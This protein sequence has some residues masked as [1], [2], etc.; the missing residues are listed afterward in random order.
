MFKNQYDT[1]CTT[2]SPM[3]RIF[4]IEY[5]MEAVKQGTP[6][7]GLRSN[8]FAILCCLKRQLGEL[9]SYQK[10]IFRIDDHLGI[11][12][13][14][15]TADARVLANYMRM[16]CLNEKY[17]FDAPL[18]IGRLISQIG[19]KSQQKTQRSSKRPYGVGL[20]VAGCDSTGPHIYETCPSGNYYEYKAFAIG[21]RSQSAKTYL[22]KNFQEF[23][24]NN[25]EDLI[26]H[27]VK[28]INVTSGETDI[29]AQN[30]S[31]AYVGRDAKFKELT[32][33]E[34]EKYVEKIKDAAGPG[35]DAM[36]T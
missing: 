27:A 22:E 21:G 11:A 8:D 28:A 15:L 9:A 5:A 14:G 26:T 2:W 33:A 19:D 12:I 1:D 35:D 18:N 13:S 24:D 32:E 17:T 4:Q 6:C 29:S 16:E 23:P 36:E 30:I 25:L 3:G 7:V 10:K 20:L 31:V 34:L